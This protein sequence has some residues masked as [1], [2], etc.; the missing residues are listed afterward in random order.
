MT[1]LIYSKISYC[2]SIL[3][4]THKHKYISYRNVPLNWI[5]NRKLRFAKVDLTTIKE[6]YKKSDTIFILGN[7]PSLNEINDSQWEHIRKHDSF[8][9][10]YSF[11][12]G[13]IPT[14]H[15]SEYSRNKVGREN[16]VK[17]FNSK[18]YRKNYKNVVFCLHS[19]YFRRLAHPRLVPLFYPENCIYYKYP[20]EKAIY[21]GSGR[22]FSDKDFDE[23]LVYRGTLCQVLQLVVNHFQYKN[24]ILL[25]VDLDNANYFYKNYPELRDYYN[26]I[27]FPYFKDVSKKTGN[28]KFD[29][30]YIKP[31][32]TQPFD[33]YLYALR[34]YLKNKKGINLYIWSRQNMLY[35][36]LPA[37]FNKIH[38]KS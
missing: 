8:G 6:K 23:S 20:V 5:K 37:Y 29:S 17:I 27:L 3:K 12:A 28:V 18:N 15:Y 24:I 25:G 33:Q 35:P 30:M 31:G 32:K 4:D 10:N 1:S 21:L 19:K 34:N 22:H 11:L 16:I 14:Y 9:I 38:N 7:G 13:H 26:N 36:G 2:M